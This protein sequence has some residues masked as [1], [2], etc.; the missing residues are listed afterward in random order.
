MLFDENRQATFDNE[1]HAFSVR[2]CPA[3]GMMGL[4]FVQGVFRNEE[5]VFTAKRRHDG[6]T[7]G[8]RRDSQ[9]VQHLLDAHLQGD[10]VWLNM[11]YGQLAGGFYTGA[12]LI[13]NLAQFPFHVAVTWFVGKRAVELKRHFSM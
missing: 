3:S 7:D 2:V 11:M 6:H 13:N 5:C 12:R 1:R 4:H 8:G 9:Q 10:H